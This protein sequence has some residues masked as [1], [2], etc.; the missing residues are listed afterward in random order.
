M[1]LA[2]YSNPSILVT[3][4]LATLANWRFV[5]CH[6]PSILGIS[7]IVIPRKLAILA[8]F[9]YWSYLTSILS[10]FCLAQNIA[11]IKGLLYIQN[12]KMYFV[13]LFYSDFDYVCN[14]LKNIYGQVK[15]SEVKITTNFSMTL[16]PKC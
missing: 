8:I 1:F 5:L 2:P 12:L 9:K 13:F 15:G 6:F 11:K 4:I 10:M 7:Y 3:S 16:I 14:I